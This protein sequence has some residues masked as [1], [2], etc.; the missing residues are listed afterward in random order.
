MAQQL[1]LLIL[2]FLFALAG[3]VFANTVDDVL[4]AK[5][6]PVG[7]VFEIVSGDVGALSEL[8]PQLRKDIDRLRKRFPELPIAIVSHGREEFLLTSDNR[9]N[10][11]EVHDFIEQIT[12]NEKID[13]H[14]C[15]THASWF[16]ISE[17]DFP[18]YVDVTPAGPT[19][20][21]DYEELGYELIVLP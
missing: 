17:E 4:S 18:D 1:K 13:V 8:T 7:V 2:A 3:S 10:A 16:G 19:Q 11:P 21:N 20:I 5:E 14:V 12:S 15:G 6:R 9:K